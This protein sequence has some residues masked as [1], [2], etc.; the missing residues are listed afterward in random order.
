LDPAR[1]D[2]HVLNS[3]E[4][5]QPVGRVVGKLLDGRNPIPEIVVI[6]GLDMYVKGQKEMDDAVEQL[7]ELLEVARHFHI[8]VIGTVGTPKLKVGESFSN[9]RDAAFGSVA[10]SR[11]S[12]T[13][14]T[15]K[16]HK[17]DRLKVTLS[18]LPRH[19]P[20]EEIVLEWIDGKLVQMSEERLAAERERR[21]SNSFLDWVLQ[22]DSFK[23]REVRKKFKMNGETLNKRLEGLCRGG[24]LKLR[25]DKGE[26]YY[27]VLH[28]V[29]NLADRD[30]DQLFD[31]AQI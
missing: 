1:V 23:K 6:E 26:E 15:L 27:E 16:P 3:K 14:W 9:D 8:A 28:A 29:S 12:E 2:H 21:E 18:M 13:I 4:A 5:R 22:Q 31:Q 7:S 17:D 30:H 11:K 10:W 25:F 20:K 19:S 24:V